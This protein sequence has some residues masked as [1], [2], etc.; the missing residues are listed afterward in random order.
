[1]R[2]VTLLPL[3]VM[4]YNLSLYY[5]RID[6]SIPLGDSPLHPSAFTYQFCLLPKVG[7]RKPQRGSLVN[8][9]HTDPFDHS[10][11]HRSENTNF[12]ALSNTQYYSNELVCLYYC[13]AR[14]IVNKLSELH[15]IM[16]NSK[17]KY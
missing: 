11:L 6:L 10:Q 1:M 5:P 7:R 12:N 15:F 4:T 8:L 17:F 13:N 3:I 9:A 14:S 16:Y 2:P